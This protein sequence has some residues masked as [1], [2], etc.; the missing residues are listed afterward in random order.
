MS[1]RI[2]Q[3]LKETNP[4]RFKDKMK[5]MCAP[6]ICELDFKYIKTEGKKKIVKIV[7]LKS[8]YVKTPKK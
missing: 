4:L 8:R 1:N 5:C 6:D 3:V 2:C 7:N